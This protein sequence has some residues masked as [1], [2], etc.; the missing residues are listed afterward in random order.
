MDVYS[1]G[2]V[3]QC[4]MLGTNVVATC[5]ANPT[6]APALVKSMKM[7]I[8]KSDS[9]ILLSSAIDHPHAKYVAT[10]AQTT[11]WCKLWDIALDRGIQG[12]RGLQT[13]LKE[14]SR[15]TYD[16]F[17]CQSCGDS[18]GEDT[19]WFD[20]ICSNHPK[21]VNNLSVEQSEGGQCRYHFFSCKLK[22]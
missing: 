21:A 12:T 11:S 19:L 14:L 15:R 3:Q 20:H 13:L 22:T 2:I 4:Q 17:Q 10:M 16:D 8:I 1:I 6:D 5:L 18:I 9:E 7:D